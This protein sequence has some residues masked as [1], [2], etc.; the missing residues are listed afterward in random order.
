MPVLALT[1]VVTQELIQV[2]LLLLLI[3]PPV[4]AVESAAG[5]V[6]PVPS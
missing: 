4:S 1:L 2:L 5:A 3:K 6:A